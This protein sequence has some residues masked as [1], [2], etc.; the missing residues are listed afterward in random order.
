MLT[1]RQQDLAEKEAFWRPHL[2]AWQ[3]SDVSVKTYCKTHGLKHH[4][5]K[6]WQYKLASDTKRGHCETSLEN[7]EF[8]EV[9][10]FVSPALPL[11]LSYEVK[12]E[13]GFCVTLSGTVH[14]ETLKSIFTI[15]KELS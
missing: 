7:A 15:I 4:Q 6:Y 11:N 2:S 10:S 14:P 3:S 12:T 5:F 13:H 9:K 1:K 8:I